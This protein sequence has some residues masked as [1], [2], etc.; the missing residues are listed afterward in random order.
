MINGI[1]MSLNYILKIFL[2]KSSFYYKIKNV[3]L[4]DTLVS[5]YIVHNIVYRIL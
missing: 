2:R 1:I 3:H 4:V 5:G